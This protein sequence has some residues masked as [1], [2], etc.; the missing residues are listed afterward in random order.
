[1]KE[2]KEDGVAHWRKDPKMQPMQLNAPAVEGQRA[3]D[4]DVSETGRAAAVV[5]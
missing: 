5:V 3:Y 1:M 2:Q 4:E